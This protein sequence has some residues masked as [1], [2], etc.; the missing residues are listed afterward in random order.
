MEGE[1]GGGEGAASDPPPVGCCL[2]RL[3]GAVVIPPP[4]G[5]CCFLPVSFLGGGVFLPFSVSTTPKKEREESSAT[6]QEEAW[7]AAPL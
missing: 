2:L 3:G 7:E 4:L 1:G 5:W 6:P